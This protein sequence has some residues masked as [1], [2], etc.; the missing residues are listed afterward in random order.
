ML[1]L[2]LQLLYAPTAVTLNSSPPHVQMVRSWQSAAHPRLSC[3]LYLF[4][5]FTSSF[6]P[7]FITPFLLFSLS[8]LLMFLSALCL[9]LLFFSVFFTPSLLPAPPPFSRSIPAMQTLKVNLH[10]KVLLLASATVT[11][12]FF[13]VPPLFP[14]F[15]FFNLFYILL[16]T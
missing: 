3:L 2:T 13:S 1:C 11:E 4:T 6:P 9:C 15:F 8:P 7:P 16:F 14:F 10:S 5:P 12:R